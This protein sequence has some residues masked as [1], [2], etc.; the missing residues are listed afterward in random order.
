MNQSDLVQFAISKN[1]ISVSATVSS[2][3]FQDTV[4]PVM[5][6]LLGEMSSAPSVGTF[7]STATN[8][9]PAKINLS[10]K[11]IAQKLNAK[12]VTE[13]LTAAAASLVLVHNKEQFSWKELL[14]ETK[15]ASGYWTKSHA[16]NGTKGR[17]TLQASGVLIENSSGELSLAPTAER[18]LLTK[19]GVGG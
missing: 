3:Y 16:T 4:L 6:S 18:D 2:S 10:V 13:V 1:G 15:K 5:S 14:A 12:S 19:L 9:Q 17:D 7:S 11:A 8:A